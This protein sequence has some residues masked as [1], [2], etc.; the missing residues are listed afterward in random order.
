MLH[1]HILHVGSFVLGSFWCD[2]FLPPGQT[3]QVWLFMIPM[4]CWVG[5]HGPRNFDCF[6]WLNELHVVRSTLYL[7]AN[8]VCMHLRIHVC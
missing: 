6:L 1:C 8:P 7:Y 3:F 4:A 2:F 5:A